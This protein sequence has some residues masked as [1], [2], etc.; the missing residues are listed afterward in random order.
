MNV[1]RTGHILCISFMMF[2]MGCATGISQQSRSKVTYKGTFS[3]LQKTPDAY[4]NEVIMLGG[5]IIEA[6]ISP[7][8]SELFV[9]QLALAQLVVPIILINPGVALLYNPGNSLIRRSIK[10]ICCSLSWE[11][12][13]GVKSCLLGISNMPILLWN[14]LRSSFGQS[15]CKPDR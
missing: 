11:N 14:P 9:L 1:Q 15:K 8:L 3:T 10:R 13:K 4:K 2:V 6:K 5:R 12:S 7:P